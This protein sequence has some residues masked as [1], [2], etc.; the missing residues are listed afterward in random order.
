MEVVVIDD[1]SPDGTWQVVQEFQ[2]K[3][4]RVHLLRRQTD[5]GRGLAGIAGFQYA[6]DHG[7]DAVVEMDADFSHDPLEIP[8]LLDKIGNA[9][10]VLGSRF[11]HGGYQVNRAFRRRFLTRCAS[12]YIK[13]ILGLRVKDPTSGFRCFTRKALQTIRLKTLK[14]RG[15]F[16]VTEIL[17]R[18]HQSGLRITEVPIAFK[19]REA[20]KTKISLGTLINNL[21]EIP[22]LRFRKE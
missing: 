15:P 14:A 9:D 17:Y 8:R 11:V 19:E 22:K 6:M 3:D 4:P 20:G 12:I 21:L 5:R 16:I 13:G 18:C 1:D 2:R 7:A 10:V